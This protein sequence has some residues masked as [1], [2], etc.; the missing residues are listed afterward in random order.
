MSEEGP[1]RLA[2]GIGGGHGRRSRPAADARFIA[3]SLLFSSPLVFGALHRPQRGQERVG[4][5]T[6]LV[7]DGFPRSGNTFALV[8]FEVAQ[9]APVRVA[10]H[11][12]ASAQVVAAARS[13][14]P[15]ILTV[16]R[17]IDAVVS[18]CQ[19]Y[20]EVSMTTA[21]LTYL[22][23]YRRCL[24][25]RDRVVAATFD[26]ITSDMGGVIDRTNARFATAFAR[27]DHT[28]ENVARCFELIEAQV[29][30]ERFGEARERVLPRPTEARESGRAELRA[31]Y[32]RL[33]AVLRR[34][35]DALYRAYLP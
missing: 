12:H 8:A 23:F 16:R 24:P 33:P 1:G 32:E 3:R 29:P 19:Y 6:E 13:G 30:E 18:H 34:R 35:A 26:E 17:P 9:P 11:T 4:P 20:A 7:I 28:E 27:F 10:H 22:V 15:V 14:L 21:L 25:F 31:R 5:G 2:P